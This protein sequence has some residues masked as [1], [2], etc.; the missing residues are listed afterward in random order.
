MTNTI[1]QI[2]GLINLDHWIGLVAHR[3]VGAISLYEDGSLPRE[4]FEHTIRVLIGEMPAAPS[5]EVME[6]KFQLN[7]LL[8]RLLTEI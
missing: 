5:L 3:A 4:A 1:E 8:E 6:E 2:K 7:S